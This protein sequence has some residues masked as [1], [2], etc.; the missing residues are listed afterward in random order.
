MKKWIA[1]IVCLFMIMPLVACSTNSEDGSSENTSIVEDSTNVASP[2]S[3]N[4]STESVDISNLK[5]GLCNINE[6][7][8]FGKLVK[9]GF[10][11]AC[12][13]RG[14]TLVY[15]D[16]NSDGQTA[17]S[18]AETMALQGVDFVVDMNTDASVGE[19]IMDIFGQASIPA[20]AVDIALPG[21]PFFGIDSN[22]LG[23]YNGE[24]ASKYVQE[25]FNGVVDYVVLITQIASGD[26]VQKR[27]RSA[28]DALDDNGI[29]Y[30]EVVEIEGKNDTAIS[31]QCFTDFLTAHPDTDSII[32]FTTNENAA[33]GVYA[34]AVT[35]GREWDKRIFSCNIGTQFTESMYETKGEQSWVSTISNFT[36]LYG[37]QCCE[38][39]EQY[40]TKGSLPDNTCCKFEAINWDNINEIYPLDNLPWNN[41]AK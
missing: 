25:N 17:V 40:F 15:A 33:Q 19:T 37:E 26:E 21:A 27:V 30:G 39:I 4:S 35:V 9:Y 24:V 29:K 10:E 31:Q 12:A 11:N 3:E 6:K 8:T 20:M 28:I 36:E 14:W 2:Q 5:I 16:N 7:G 1:L 32:V 18:N 22:A 34:A 13:E 41:F 23:Y 38:L